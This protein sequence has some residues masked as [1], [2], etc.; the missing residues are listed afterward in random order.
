MV[1]DSL[2]GWLVHG[3]LLGAVAAV[4]VLLVFLVGTR[5]IGGSSPGQGR[6]DPDGLRRAEVRAY[7]DAIGEPAEEGA[8]VHGVDVDFWLPDRAIA[9]T[10]DAAAYFHLTDAGTEAVLLEHE[11]P[12]DQLGARLPFETPPIRTRSR[13]RD[14]ISWAHEVLD[15]D[16]T[17]DEHAIEDAYRTQIKAVH[18]DVGGSQKALIEVLEAYEILSGR[19]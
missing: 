3:L 16:A 4:G 8:I 12:G 9:I 17:A 2:P 7:L 11:V 18:P 15:V 14:D 19:E 13:E 6:Y 1:I 5:W 10:F